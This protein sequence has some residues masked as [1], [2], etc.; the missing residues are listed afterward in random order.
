VTHKVKSP[1]SQPQFSQMTMGSIGLVKLSP[2]KLS[3]RPEMLSKVATEYFLKNYSLE[4]S[5]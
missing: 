1:E 4:F 3:G 2:N 5:D